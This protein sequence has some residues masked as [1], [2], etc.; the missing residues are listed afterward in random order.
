MLDETGLRRQAIQLATMLPEDHDDALK[1]IAMVADI[2]NGFI[3]PDTLK[4]SPGS[5]VIKLVPSGDGAA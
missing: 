5:R 1:V 2:A 3:W 4:G